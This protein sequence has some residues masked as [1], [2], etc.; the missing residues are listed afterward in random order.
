MDNLPLY[1]SEGEYRGMSSRMF[2]SLVIGAGVLPVVW[3]GVGA[4]FL[5]GWH[6]VGEWGI[7]ILA[8][9]VMF[10]ALSAGLTWRRNS[11]SPWHVRWDRDGIEVAWYR[12]APKQFR[13]EEL[14]RLKDAEDE[15]ADITWV[16][17]YSGERF[18]I[19]S[20]S[21]GYDELRAA[22]AAHI[23]GSQD[24]GSHG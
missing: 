3:L 8:G 10:G 20:S 9:A 7:G 12:G 1:P 21:A 22:L 4:G 6:W 11:R 5:L 17:T 2:W 14:Q 16:R 19:R 13:W 23:W 18:S 15:D 24:G